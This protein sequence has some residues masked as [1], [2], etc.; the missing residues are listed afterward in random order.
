MAVPY[1]Q[2]VLMQSAAVANGNGTAITPTQG[3]NGSFPVL[4][5]QVQGITTATINWEG[6][7]DGTNFVAIP[8]Q[9]VATQISATTTTADGIFRINTAGLMSIRARISGWSAGTITVTGVCSAAGHP[10]VIT[11]SA[12][13]RPAAAAATLSNV[14]SSATN[15]TVL[16]ANANRKG[17]IIVNDSTAYLYLKF[18]A[19]ATTSSYTVKLYPDDYYEVP[20]PVYVGII[21][22]IWSAANGSARVTELT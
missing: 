19:T 11:L 2:K 6:S 5:A 18:G 16:A 9:N 8:A 1:Y 13:V 12:T 15:V 3:D 10:G 20:E 21:D 22:G 17:A 7:I 4:T 14:A